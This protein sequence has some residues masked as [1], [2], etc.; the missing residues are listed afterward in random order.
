MAEWTC[1][2]SVISSEVRTLK[3]ETGGCVT[4]LDSSLRWAPFR[5]TED[6]GALFRMTKDEGAGFRMRGEG[7]CVQDDRG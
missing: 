5:M 3:A 4:T 2:A 7:R 6:E 1:F